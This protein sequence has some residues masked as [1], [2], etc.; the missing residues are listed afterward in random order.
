[1]RL[2]Y[3]AATILFIA[4]VWAVPVDVSRSPSLESIL[5]SSTCQLQIP[6][7][8]NSDLHARKSDTFSNPRPVPSHTPLAP[9]I[10]AVSFLSAQKY[11]QIHGG[12][13]IDDAPC[14]PTE[15]DSVEQKIRT[16]LHAAVQGTAN[17]EHGFRV[18]SHPQPIIAFH[19]RCIARLLPAY[20][21]FTVEVHNGDGGECE[22]QL[23]CYCEI[24]LETGR[25]VLKSI[26]RTFYNT[27]EGA[28]SGKIVDLFNTL[29]PDN[30]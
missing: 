28:D 27:M 18:R 8:S 30:H 25:G 29:R 10:I 14:S 15:Q 9:S 12:I 23:P 26:Q 21:A 24:L 1:M 22:W 2:T 20:T 5:D 16:L 19:G 11:R 3:Y 6:G 7:S 13:I 17:A 4:A